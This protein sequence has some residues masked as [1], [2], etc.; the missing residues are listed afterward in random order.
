LSRQHNDE[1]I[2]VVYFQD[3]NGYVLVAP[4]RSHPTPAGFERQECH[5]LREVDDLTR[6]LN[7]Q[8]SNMFSHMWE[9]DRQTM[10]ES[11]ERHRTALRQRLLAPDCGPAERVFIKRAFAYFDKKE[12]EYKHYHVNGYF[13]QR[14]YDSPGSDPIEKH[15]R[16]LEATVPKLSDRLASI[17]TGGS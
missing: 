8:D 1:R 13:H 6:K 4:D 16:Q 11:H 12:E 17:L 14:E 10:I 7:R 2:C 3:A 9:K 15:G 5:T